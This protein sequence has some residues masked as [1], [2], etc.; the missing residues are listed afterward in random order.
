[1]SLSPFL[2]GVRLARFEALQCRLV[3]RAA[4]FSDEERRRSCD[5]V[6]TFLARQPDATRRK[7]AVFLIVID[8]LSLFRGLAPFRALKPLRQQALLRWLFDAPVGLLRKGFWGLNTL[9]RLGVYGQTQL[10]EEIAY[11]VRDNPTEPASTSTPTNPR[12][13]AHV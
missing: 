7:L 8:V 9:A 3:P 10:Y 13:A 12:E 2:I 1:M 6:E 11:R 5:L 4:R